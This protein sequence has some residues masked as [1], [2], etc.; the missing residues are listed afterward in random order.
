MIGVRN[1]LLIDHGRIDLDIRLGQPMAA[2]SVRKRLPG[3]SL[4]D[5]ARVAP[6]YRPTSRSRGVAGARD[7]TAGTPLN[8]KRAPQSAMAAGRQLGALIVQAKLRD[9]RYVEQD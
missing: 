9:S 1:H 8:W 4:S 3:S 6:C 7:L 5:T 2:L